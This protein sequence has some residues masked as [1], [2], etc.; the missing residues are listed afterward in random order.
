MSFFSHLNSSC[1]AKKG[2]KLKL[3]CFRKKKS[4][5][6]LRCI[7]SFSFLLACWCK[8]LCICNLLTFCI[9]Y[10]YSLLLLYLH[11]NFFYANYFSFLISF[12]FYFLIWLCII[13]YALKWF[14][15]ILPRDAHLRSSST[16]PRSPP[17]PLSSRRQTHQLILLFFRCT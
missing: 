6:H 3:L 13:P 8:G 14:S 17:S 16:A 11:F 9:F 1:T 12:F 10:T 4:S 2:N 15:V 5:I 7:F